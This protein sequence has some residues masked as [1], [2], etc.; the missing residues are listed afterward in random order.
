MRKRFG[1]ISNDD[2]IKLLMVAESMEKD[3]ETAKRIQSVRLVFEG[4]AI[5]EVAHIVNCCDKTVYNNLNKYA[6][7]GFSGLKPKPKSGR[8]HKLTEGQET[9]LYDTISNKLPSEVG[10]APFSNWTSP[11]AARWIEQRFGIPFTQRG[12]R[13]LFDRLGLSF[14]RPTYTLKKADPQR[15]GQFRCDFEELKKS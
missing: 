3:K 11:L 1:K 10:L 13:N 4:H 9:E 15:Q 2:E 6:R 7:D 12:V 8:Q 14:T 5:P